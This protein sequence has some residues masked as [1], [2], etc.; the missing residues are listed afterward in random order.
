MTAHGQISTPHRAIGPGG[1]KASA[2]HRPVEDTVSA[3]LWNGEEHAALLDLDPALADGIPALHRSRAV[4]ASLGHLVRASAG[5][6]QPATGGHGVGL[7]V[8]DG[9]VLH[10]TVWGQ[11]VAAELLGPGDLLR[12]GDGADSGDT[13]QLDESWHV[14]TPMWLGR[15]DHAWCARMASWPEVS[16]ELTQRSMASARRAAELFALGQ[17]RRLDLRVWLVLWRLA[18]RFGRVHL[19]GVHLDVPLT[20]QQLAELAGARRPSV[21]AAV[22]RLTR[23]GSVRQVDGGWLLDGA[24]PPT[25]DGAPRG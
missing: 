23:V 5:E 4:R 22:S 11:R 24:P 3:D 7:L 20:H 19:D 25:E 1:G 12:V 15:L 9:L 17:V 13:L 18:D 10:R 8:I 6:W 14:L 16:I 2:V 21:S